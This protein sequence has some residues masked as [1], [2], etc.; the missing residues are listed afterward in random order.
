[1]YNRKTIIVM[2][3]KAQFCLLFFLLNAINCWSQ[4]DAFVLNNKNIVTPNSDN[5]MF[6]E[7]K[8]DP[9]KKIKYYHVEEITSMKFGGFKTVYN[10][11]N[12]KLIRNYD[13]GPNNKRIITPVYTHKTEN[14][15]TVL[16]TETLVAIKNQNIIIISDKPKKENSYANIDI[17]KT[18]ERVLEKGYESLDMLKK[19]ANSYY[20]NNEFEKAEQCY[21]K[22]FAKTT[23]LEAEFYYRYSISLKSVGKTEK[24]IE[25]LKKF[26]QLS[27]SETK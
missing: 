2:K 24:S 4:I 26:N 27:S 21:G 5:M 13:L 10:V 3:N 14:D 7:K 20:F 22:L 18:Y 6:N 9:N 23:E 12:P 8:I 15:N 11:S 25:Y 17:I 16:K 19:I 1:M